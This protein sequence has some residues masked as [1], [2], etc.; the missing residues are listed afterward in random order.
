MFVMVLRLRDWKRGTD[1]ALLQFLRSLHSGQSRV[2]K[3]CRRSGKFKL[4]EL[5][6]A[7]FLFP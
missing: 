5:V 6:D 3:T 1:C 7:F 4:T 2:A